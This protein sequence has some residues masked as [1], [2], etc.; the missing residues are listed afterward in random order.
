MERLE[1]QVKQKDTDHAEL[2]EQRIKERGDLT[3]QI[4]KKNE[5]V[6]ALK[7][8]LSKA[9]DELLQIRAKCETLEKRLQEEEEATGHSP[10]TG[11]MLER[12]SIKQNRLSECVSFQPSPVVMGVSFAFFHAFILPAS[13]ALIT[14]TPKPSR[15]AYSVPP[16][17]VSSTL[18]RQQW[19]MS[20]ATKLPI[21]LTLMERRN[22]TTSKEIMM[23]RL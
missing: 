13:H 16:V 9:N 23:Q 14:K 17:A 5:E 4:E 22:V 15:I 11:Y 12:K 2:E 1:E 6:E 18:N 21:L 7:T 10:Q 19:I 20:D 8:K 3:T